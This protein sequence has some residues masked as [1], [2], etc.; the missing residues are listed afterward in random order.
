MRRVQLFVFGL[1]GLLGLAGC[2]VKP[3][4]GE[5]RSDR[6]C[7]AEAAGGVCVQ[8]RCQE[9]GADTDCKPGFVCRSWKCLPRPECSADGDCPEG[10]ACEGERCVARKAAAAP[11]ARECAAHADC[12]EGRRCDAD[13]RCV[14]RSEGDDPACAEPGAWVVRFGFD[15]SAL[16]PDAQ[17]KLQKIAGCLRAKP[18]AKVV[19]TGHCD[20]RGTTEYNLALGSRRAEAA[21]KYLGGL[22]VGGTLETV[23]LGK[24]RP[25]CTESNEG[26]WAQNRRAEIMVSR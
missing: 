9:C 15:E 23:T 20:E 7:A 8:G 12:G 1:V 25:L 4:S 11:P 3:K 21:R 14:D 17:E 2:P 6:D 19:V 24:E 5:C 18:A 13:G 26:C 10:K 22:G 16:I